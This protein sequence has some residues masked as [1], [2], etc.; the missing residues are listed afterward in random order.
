M[1]WSADIVSEPS[2]NHQLCIDLFEGG[3]HRARVQRNECGDLE[4]VCY[5]GELTIPAEW[6]VGIIQRFIA[7]TSSA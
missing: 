4:L 7:E 1:T 6:L 5:G 3:T 2:Q